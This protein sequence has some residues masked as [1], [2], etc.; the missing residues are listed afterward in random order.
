[1]IGHT[2]AP[3]PSRVLSTTMSAIA[4]EAPRDDDAHDFVGAFEDLMHA[5]VAQKRSTGTSF[6]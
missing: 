3:T 2:D 5:Q 4:E 6:K 1:M